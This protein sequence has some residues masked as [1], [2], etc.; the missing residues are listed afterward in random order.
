[1]HNRETSRK[2]FRKHQDLSFNLKWQ[3]NFKLSRTSKL[4]RFTI[5]LR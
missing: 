3:D 2:R 5:V 1:M 4:V